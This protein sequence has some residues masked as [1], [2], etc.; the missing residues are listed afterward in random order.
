MTILLEID[1]SSLI[2]ITVNKKEEIFV[3]ILL[4]KIKGKI[5]YMKAHIELDKAKDC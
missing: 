3:D 1:V 4:N 2:I 5:R